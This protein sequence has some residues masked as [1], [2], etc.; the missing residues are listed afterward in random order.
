MTIEPAGRVN[1]PIN[2]TGLGSM[3]Q[4]DDIG[5]DIDWNTLEKSVIGNIGQN[6]NPE[7]EQQN[8]D[9]DYA[10]DIQRLSSQFGI[11]PGSS[12]FD[13]KTTSAKTPDNR[14]L[15]DN[16]SMILSPPRVPQQTLGNKTS[17]QNGGFFGNINTNTNTNNNNNTNSHNN[18][19]FSGSNNEYF[20]NSQNYQ[21][22]QMKLMTHEQRN[23][24][25][26]NSVIGSLDNE[27]QSSSSGIT[28]ELAKD[29][30]IDNK[31]RQLDQIHALR[32]ALL[33]ENIDIER[34]PNVSLENSNSE[35]KEVLSYLLVISDNRRCS[36]LAEEL[37]LMGAQGAGWVCNGK[38]KFLGRRP[39]LT[40]W[41]KTVAVKLRHLRH[42]TSMLVSRV[43]KKYNIGPGWRIAMELLPS[44]FYH[45]AI[46]SKRT[47][48][49]YISDN[50]FNDAMGTIRDM[51]E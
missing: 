37:I 26:I 29:R 1:D 43:M 13:S 24:H 36:S 10:K 38:R 3:F 7:K 4:S 5:S 8:L 25:V 9:Q 20:G 48:N 51:D 47:E 28:A 45:S 49:D 14:N 17:Q 18:G 27:D 6:F 21:D 39:D 40:D 2:I 41:H 30:E 16:K 32:T 50:E 34:I 19:F 35:I 12:P 23:K 46:R 15:F 33:E 42:D 31:I 44:M 11:D 22:P